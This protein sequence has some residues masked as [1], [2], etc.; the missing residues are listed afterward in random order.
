VLDDLELAPSN[1]SRTLNR[2]ISDPG[3]DQDGAINVVN[4]AP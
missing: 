4:D 2:S 1:L 3:I